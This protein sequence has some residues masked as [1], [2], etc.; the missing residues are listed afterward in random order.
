MSEA[1]TIAWFSILG[2][3]VH[4]AFLKALLKFWLSHWKK[5]SQTSTH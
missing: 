3:T 1:L 2:G 5:L 4:R